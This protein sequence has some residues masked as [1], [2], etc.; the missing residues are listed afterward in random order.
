VFEDFFGHRAAVTS[1]ET[2]IRRDRIPQTLLIAGQEGVGK[3]TLVRRFA[4]RLLGNPAAIER[5][6]LSLA[7]NQAILAE[8][9][10]WPSERRVE[11]PLYFNSHP[12]FVTFPPDGPLRQISIQ[13]MRLLKDRA[14]FKPL[15]GAWRVFL[16][17]KLDRANE[18]AANSLLKVLEEPPPHLVLFLTAQNVYDLL[19]TIRSRSICLHVAAL[20]SSEM[21]EFARARGIAESDRRLALAGGC[22]G[23]ALTLDLEAYDMRRAA[24]LALLLAAAGLSGFSSWARFSDAISAS[25]S[26]RLEPYL[27]ILYGLCADVMTLQ[28]GASNLRNPDVLP[29]LQRLASSV[30]FDWL[31]QAV[32]RADDIGNLLRRNIQK[33]IALDAMVLHLRAAAG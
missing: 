4:A 15:K 27:N 8:R 23:A 14:R 22:P 6:D 1:L 12:D 16:I 32:T 11:E 21:A 29:Q 31:R 25:R 30:S 24:M 19:P 17:D 13:Q 28:C 3:A 10:K 2:M 33:S 20:S 5:D 26:E 7:S 18:Q 9:E